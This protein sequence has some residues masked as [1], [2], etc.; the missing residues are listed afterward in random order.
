MPDDQ[1]QAA[2]EAG[3]KKI[4]FGTDLCYSFLDEVFATSRDLIA[5]DLFMR[6]PVNAVKAFAVEKIRLL[7][8]NEIL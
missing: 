3:I 7:H 5:I 8:G 2:V 4:N 6:G 1:I